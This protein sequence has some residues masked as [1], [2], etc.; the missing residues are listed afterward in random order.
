M[1]LDDLYREV[2]LEHY[3]HPRNKGEIADAE[4]DLLQNNPLCG[5]EVHLFVKVM[6]GRIA[7]AE[8]L[9]QGCSISQASA[10]MMTEMLEGKSLE[11][12][13]ALATAFGEMMQGT[14]SPDASALGELLA[15]Q[16]VRMYP[17]RIKCAVL[18]WETLQ[19]GLQNYQVKVSKGG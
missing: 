9:G 8:F 16:G 3:R 5:D 7:D 4:I 17:V 15:L 19:K 18:A 2:I 1:S 13:K 6:D 12:A 10:S 14:L 11:E